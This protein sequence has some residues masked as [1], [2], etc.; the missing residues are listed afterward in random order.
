MP[1]EVFRRHQKK[2]IAIFGILAMV[3]FLVPAGVSNM[4]ASR[5]T[6][7]DSEVVRLYGRPV[8]R[9]EVEA[10]RAERLRANAFFYRLQ[11]DLGAYN[12][13]F[14]P[15]PSAFGPTDTRSIVD[16]LILKHEADALGMPVNNTAALQLLKAET[17][18]R[19]TPAVAE[20]IVDQT[21]KGQLVSGEMILADIADQLRLMQAGRLPG[22]PEVTPLDVYEAFREQ[23]EKVAVRA[24][25]VRVADFV[26]KVPEPT[27]AQIREFYATYKDATP[28]PD[29]PTPGFTAPRRVR[30]EFATIDGSALDRRYR[31]RLTE[32]EVR[33]A[34]EER[35]AELDKPNPMTDELP[36]D[37]FA[38]DTAADAKHTARTFDEVRNTLENDL[39]DA[40]VQDEI[41]RKFD[42]LR[43][44]MSEYSK[45]YD[46]ATHPA[47]EDEESGKPVPPGAPP[48]LPQRP[49][50]KA[51]AAKLGVT[52]ESTPLLT[53]E[54]LA[55]Y[56]NLSK[57][58]VGAAD[59]GARSQSPASEFF[60]PKTENFVPTDLADG[61]GRSFLAWKVEDVPPRTPPLE[62]IRGE[63]VAAWKLDQARPLAR[64][65]AEDLAAAAREKHAGDLR[66][67]AGD[68]KV[69]TS[70]SPSSKL[71]AS[72]IPGQ[73]GGGAPRPAEL[74]EFP[75]AGAALRD[76]IYSLADKAVAVAPDQPE[77]TY[78]VLAVHQRL[79]ARFTD[80]YAPFSERPMLEMRALQEAN[81]R[82][83]ASWIGYLRERAGMKP[84]WSPPNE[85]EK[86]DAHTE[87]GEETG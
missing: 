3:A 69:I 83:S 84:D 62:E 67:V 79:P 28:D 87:D 58:H 75:K 41:K 76:A 50:L 23:T 68:R 31:A 53:R 5:G 82:R 42:E 54:V 61:L 19:M 40:R 27:D 55:H 26:A 16:A 63:V 74:P 77:S 78:Y 34:F 73:F 59:A 22:P 14:G 72:P 44:V 8:Y 35:K 46:D 32:K 86:H 7:V 9:S 48:T 57:S 37:L 66:A 51:L 60:N 33:D 25:P 29:R 4:F 30:L 80:L 36:V 1:F 52:Y 71:V 10:M 11:V 85:T 20:R 70:E 39:V 24:I 17:N 12:P 21:F 47:T 18:D 45:A 56:G 15:N 65:A 43:D 2:L 49:D 6:A 13:R 64:K 81:A 38:A